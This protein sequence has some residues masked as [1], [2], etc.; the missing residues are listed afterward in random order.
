MEIGGS[1]IVAVIVRHCDRTR[2]NSLLC[3]CSN[4][5]VPLLLNWEAA[6][7]AKG[8]QPELLDTR[9]EKARSHCALQ[10]MSPPT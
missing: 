8:N 1:V 6:V 3:L 9:W 5:S 10:G 7:M 2:E 4:A